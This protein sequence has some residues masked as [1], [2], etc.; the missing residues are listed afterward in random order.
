M[1]VLITGGAGYIGSHAVLAFR[2]AGYEV[3]VVDDLSTG[4]REAVPAAVP[5]IKGDS[6]NLGLAKKAFETHGITSVVHFAGSVVVPESV[7]YPLAYYLN[8]TVVSRNLI[9]ACV[10]SGVERKT[11]AKSRAAGRMEIGCR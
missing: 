9:R 7:E 10:D 6:G 11:R 3:V 8:N 4:R 5:F 1:T 2:E